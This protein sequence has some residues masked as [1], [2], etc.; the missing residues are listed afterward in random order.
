L[1]KRLKRK[2]LEK[3]GFTGLS[4]E[5]KARRA[6]EIL[7]SS[8]EKQAIC[9]DIVGTSHR[10]VEKV[11]RSILDGID[12]NKTFEE[13]F[14]PEK[15]FDPEPEVQRPSS[16]QEITLTE[17]IDK[18]YVNWLVQESTRSIAL[19]D[20]DKEPLDPTKIVTWY[21]EEVAA[22]MANDYH[23]SKFKYRKK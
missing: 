18:E 23:P 21:E 5:D 15:Y 11:M 12:V 1:S 20:P 10:D 9:N 17:I 3:C 19:E 7:D 6:Q 22:L 16:A 8:E 4:R 13:N 14:P 2:I